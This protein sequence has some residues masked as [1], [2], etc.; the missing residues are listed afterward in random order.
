MSK[1]EGRIVICDRCGDSIFL[2]RYTDFRKPGYDNA[3]EPVPKEWGVVTGGRDLCPH[4][5]SKYK[6]FMYEFLGESVEDGKENEE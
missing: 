3:I 4:C 2:E 1:K 6:E 5:Y